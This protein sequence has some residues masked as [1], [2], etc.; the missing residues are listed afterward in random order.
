LAQYNARTGV[1]WPNVE[2]R[3]AEELSQWL[4]LLVVEEKEV[5]V[6][7]EKLDT[8]SLVILSSFKVILPRSNRVRS[9]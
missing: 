4:E 8:I 6:V 7:E 3:L 2:G 5:V 9:L 1:Q